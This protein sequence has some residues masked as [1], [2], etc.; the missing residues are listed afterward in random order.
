[1]SYMYDRMYTDIMLKN[2]AQV[3]CRKVCIVRDTE[4]TCIGTHDIY[5][6]CII[7]YILYIKLY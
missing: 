4:G 5:M 3:K 7:M 2:I 6:T 1:M